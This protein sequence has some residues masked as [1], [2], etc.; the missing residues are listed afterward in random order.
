MV[1]LRGFCYL[2][3]KEKGSVQPSLLQIRLQVIQNDT[4]CVCIH[5][6]SFNRKFLFQ[7]GVLIGQA[8]IDVDK[9][10]VQFFRQLL[11]GLICRV[12]GLICTR[13]KHIQSPVIFQKLVYYIRKQSVSPEH[14]N[15]LNEWLKLSVNDMISADDLLYLQ[16]QGVPYRRNDGT[17][18]TS[19]TL[20]IIQRLICHE[21]VMLE[22]FH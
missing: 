11:Y 16:H 22:I 14:G 7:T 12:D 2:F 20:T 10:A 13:S 1:L 8:L 9:P 5:V 4:V 6:D 18:V 21:I 3:S 15:V 17:E 19:N